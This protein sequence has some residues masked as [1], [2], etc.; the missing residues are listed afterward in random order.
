MDDPEQ[1]KLILPYGSGVCSG[2]M[3][4]DTMTWGGHAVQNTT[5]AEITIE[6]GEVW[7]VSPFD[8]IAG[9]AFPF[10][11]M[12]QGRGP[13]TPFEMLVQSG[14]VA[15]D[16]FSFF[17]STEHG[18]APGKHTSQL[19][20]GGVDDTLFSGDFKY[21]TARKLEGED[22]AYWLIYGQDITIGGEATG[23]CK[24]LT[25]RCQFVV[26][27]GTSI[28]TGPSDKINPMI[29][30]IG[31]VSSDCSNIDSLPTL[32][33]KINGETYTLEP[34]YYVLKVA[35]SPGG[36][37]ECELGLMALNQLGLWILGDPFLRKYYTVFDRTTDPPRVGFATANQS[38]S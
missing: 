11:A 12:P 21:N 19:V 28:I 3:S 36:P 10:A 13:V 17:L 22:Y 7:V 27:T 14:A 8:G 29:E 5:F 18:N 31:N 15:K 20:L 30:K 9:M 4:V 32:E 34:E 2:K 23:A 35:D 38:K 16:Q 1:R 24:D 25:G 37:Y 33:F 26:D 6:P